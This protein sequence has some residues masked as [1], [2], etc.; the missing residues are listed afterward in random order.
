MSD[1]SYQ[2]LPGAE[3]VIPGLADLAAGRRTEAALLVASG[4]SSLREL[5]IEISGIMPEQP[6][7]ALYDLLAQTHGNEAHGRYNALIRRL[8]SFRRALQGIFKESSL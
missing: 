3:L 8:V 4:S 6:E 1:H 7:H 5:G 2:N